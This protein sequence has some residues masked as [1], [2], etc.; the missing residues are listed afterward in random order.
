MALK[1]LSMHCDFG[2]FL[3]DA[4]R[5]HLV[6]GLYKE[7]TQ[8]RLLTEGELTF[9]KACE[10]TQ[11]ME[12]AYKNASKLKSEEIKPSINVLKSHQGK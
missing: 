1:E 11:A 5:D 7:A 10:I 2:T 9:K 6:C 4:L 3:N 12:M 8:K